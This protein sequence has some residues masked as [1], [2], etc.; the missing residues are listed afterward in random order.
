MLEE[1]EVNQ[2][3]EESQLGEVPVVGDVKLSPKYPESEVDELREFAS[4][5]SANG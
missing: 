2:I 3:T 5:P 4:D 1:E